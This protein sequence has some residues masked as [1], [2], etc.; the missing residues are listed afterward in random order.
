MEQ[1]KAISE[2]KTDA[3]NAS[4]NNVRINVVVVNLLVLNLF[5]GFLAAVGIGFKLLQNP[6]DY[7]PQEIVLCI[8]LYI[9]FRLL[10]NCRW[11]LFAFWGILCLNA[12]VSILMHYNVGLNIGLLIVWVL[13]FFLPRNGKTSWRIILESPQTNKMEQKDK[14]TLIVIYSII[15]IA[16]IA[17]IAKNTINVQQPSSKSNGSVMMQQK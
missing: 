3:A 7:I 17:G 14:K 16:I 13:L 11:A 9:I 8:M 15:M 2:N 1:E 10:A 12:I 4:D 5:I 6:V